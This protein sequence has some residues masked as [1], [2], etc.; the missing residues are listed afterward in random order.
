MTSLPVPAWFSQLIGQGLASL[1]LL[2]LDGCPANDATARVCSLWANA[3]WVKRRWFEDTDA[4]CIREAFVS[5]CTSVKRWPAP[6]V[7]LEHMP[8]R[9]PPKHATLMN[10]DHGR[11]RE[12]EAFAGMRR[13]FAELKL[14]DYLPLHVLERSR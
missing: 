10:P 8:P 3:L 12:P 5:L 7:F 1:Y 4:A 13:Q 2:G 11:E 14:T 9:S 6:A